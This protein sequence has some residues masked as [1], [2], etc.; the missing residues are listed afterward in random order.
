MHSWFTKIL[1]FSACG[2][3]IGVAVAAGGD[4][5]ELK[6]PSTGSISGQAH[7]EGNPPEPLFFDIRNF[8]NDRYC[9]RISDGRGNRILQ[10]VR[11]DGDGL[12]QDAVVYFPDIRAGRALAFQGTDV[13]ARNCEF[14]V[15]GGPSSFTGVVMPGGELRLLNEDAD[16]NDPGLVMGIAHNPHAFEIS[17]FRIQT[18]FKTPL[19]VKGQTITKKVDLK[20]PQSFIK[21]ECDLHDYMQTYF[22]PVQNPYYAIVDKTGNYAID[23]I[24][25]GPH[26]VLA[27]HP[28]LGK[29]EKE[30]VVQAGKSI[31]V[32]F[33]FEK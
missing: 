3:A 8:P 20:N 31:Q 11:V 13:V 21:L 17:G 29:V 1:L 5:L 12:L 23:G 16:P 18:L 4:Y 9:R 24:V 7:F 6:L 22:L 28:L 14:H 26:R 33:V 2:W 25:P 19:T 10:E 15:Q 32:D 30:I 27:W